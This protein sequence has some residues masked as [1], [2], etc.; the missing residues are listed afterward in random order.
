MDWP[1]HDNLR[2]VRQEQR[3]DQLPRIDLA[4][5]TA[6]IERTRLSTRDG[7]FPQ[8]D[9]R[10]TGQ[11]HRHGFYAAASRE[12]VHDAVCHRDDR[13]GTETM[14]QAGDGDT[15]SEPIVVP[16]A[17][18]APEADGWLLALQ[19]RSAS[20]TSDLIVLDTHDIK[21]GPVGTVSLPC[22]VPAGFHGSFAETRA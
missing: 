5:R 15:L 1:D 14:F 8:I 3:L 12:G 19:Y 4:R 22:R 16:C 7:E 20:R 21:A 10:L 11:R 18:G 9:A 6:P 13:S 17:P 2:P